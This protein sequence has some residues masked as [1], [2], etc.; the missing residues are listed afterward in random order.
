MPSASL[1]L[2]DLLEGRSVSDIASNGCRKDLQRVCNLAQ[3]RKNYQVAAEANEYLGEYQAAGVFYRRAGLM[4][5]SL[6]CFIEG[7]NQGDYRCTTAA[8]K[9][10]LHDRKHDE[11]KRLYLRNEA[12]DLRL[13]TLIAK[14][15]ISFT[16]TEFRKIASGYF[17]A[18]K[19]RDKKIE[20]EQ[21]ARF[22]MNDCAEE[23]IQTYGINVIKNSEF[24][25][26]SV[27]ENDYDNRLFEQ[28]DTELLL[29]NFKLEEVA[30]AYAARVNSLFPDKNI[31]T[32]DIF[33]TVWVDS[34]RKKAGPLVKKVMKFEELGAFFTEFGDDEYASVDR[35]D[36]NDLV[37]S[38][39][40]DYFLTNYTD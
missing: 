24:S 21:S 12:G 22:L 11:A 4:T 32:G 30:E 8:I 33:T 2:E 6:N 36:F 40:R 18:E 27:Y 35:Q 15:N 5:E 39:M 34:I 3:E 14:R 37:R 31:F 9:R 29:Q 17:E 1:S 23:E 13:L 25:L 16:P 20:P 26:A 19:E 10:M 38:K 28:Y 7:S